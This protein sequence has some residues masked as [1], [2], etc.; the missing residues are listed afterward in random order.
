M[1]TGY[2]LHPAYC[3]TQVSDGARILRLIKQPAFF[4]GRY[5][6][7]RIA[8]RPT[9]VEE[10]AVLSLLMMVLLERDRG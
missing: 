10:L 8:E 2:L 6:I 7:E 9:E 4:E 3:V 1:F 5:R